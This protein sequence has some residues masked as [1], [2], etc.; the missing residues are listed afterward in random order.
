MKIVI[1]KDRCIGA[2]MCQLEAPKIFNQG[3]DDGLVVFIHQPTAPEEEQM[4]QSAAHLCPSG[5]IDIVEDA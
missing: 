3:I 5:T 4:A 2:G 1:H